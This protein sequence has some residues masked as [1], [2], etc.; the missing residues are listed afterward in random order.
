MLNYW[1]VS[2][3]KRKLDSIPELL[4]GIA[5]VVLNQQWTGM[6]E[7]HLLLEKTL[8][9]TGLKRIGERRDQSGSGGRT[10]LAWL[11]SLGLLFTQESTGL[12][13]FTLAGEAL[14]EGKPPLPILKKQVLLYQFPSSYSV[15]AKVQIASRFK[16]HPFWVILRL[17]SDTRIK[18]LSQEEIALILC[19]ECINDGDTTYENMVRRI[20]ASRSDPALLASVDYSTLY[21]TSAASLNDIANTMLNWLEYTQLICRSKGASDSIIHIQPERQSEVYEIIRQPLRFIDR[22][23]DEEYFQRKYGIDPEHNKDTRNLLATRTVTDT[24]LAE[25]KIK[26]AFLTLAARKPIFSV[27]SDIIEQIANATGY[28]N[29]L[30]EDTLLKNYAKGAI[31]SFLTSYYQMAFS[32]RNKATD[33]ELATTDLFHSVLGFESYHVGPIGLTPDV[34]IISSKDGFQGIIDNKAYSEYTISNDHRNRMI[35]NYIKGIANYQKSN[36][37]LAF[38]TYIAG[39]FSKNIDQQ[40]QSITAETSI[41]GSAMSVVRMID[42]IERHQQTP[43]AHCQLKDIFSVGRQI[44]I[45]DL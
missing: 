33:F 24:I 10:Y 37:P 15:G 11:K 34:E 39:G 7:T 41:N 32:G 26:T 18:Y 2:R 17:L 23:E 45:T 4:S 29:M 42:L 25:R 38:F 8:E 20:L 35:H 16:V 6:R 9:D 43:Y 30:V 13:Q 40:L 5:E 22:P 12:I 44:S 36:Q 27:K 19:C 21:G 28:S 1:F 14:L 3:P 31:G